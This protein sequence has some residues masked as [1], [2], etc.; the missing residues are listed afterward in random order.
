MNRY[1]SRSYYF[2]NT[3]S[4]FFRNGFRPWVLFIVLFFAVT[5]VCAQSVF[6]SGSTGTDGALSPS[7]NQTLQV[8]E[9]GVFN[10]TTINIPS[11]VT[12]KFNRNSRNTPVTLLATGNV[13]I[14][15]TISV[16]GENG[17]SNGVGGKGGPSGWP[18][19]NGGINVDLFDG[20][21]G[22]GPGGGTGGNYNGTG[23][24]GGG[25]GGFGAAGSNAWANPVAPYGQGGPT[26]G[27]YSLLPLT[28][29]SGG[30][31]GAAN[32][33]ARGTSGGGGGGAILIASSGTISLTGSITT[34]GGNGASAPP[35]ALTGT[36][37]GGSGGAVRLIA[38][39]I[40]GTGMIDVRGGTGGA[41]TYQG[42]NGGSGGRGHIKAEAY[43]YTAFNPNTYT[44]PFNITMPN[45]I[46]VPNGAELKIT[47]IAGATVPL[48]T[49]GTFA[50]APDIVFPTS[51]ANPVQ[52]QLQAANVPVDSVVQVAITPTSGARTTFQSSP[53]TQSG[54]VLTATA[55]INLPAGMSVITATLTVDLQVAKLHPIYIDGEKIVRYEIASTLGGGSETVFIT[56]GGKRVK[57]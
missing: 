28:G 2:M 35:Y 13:T 11:G 3:T 26:Y 56:A 50:A 14:G 23:H 48:V 34:V 47:S 7:S 29:G 52:I 51:L 18:G 32:A 1:V 16:N 25:G 27:T 4:T 44:V 15:G 41:L 17:L 39:T 20:R 36:G 49:N 21:N 24:W 43:D 8:P 40:S 12:V 10:F 37:G 5:G 30:G 33:T 9:S 45:P 57:L 31:G 53:L 54:A 22:D 55:S 19:G 6:D 46:F 42:Y 38:N